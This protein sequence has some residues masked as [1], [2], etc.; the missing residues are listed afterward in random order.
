MIESEDI[1]A[2]EKVIN[3]VKEFSEK[4]LIRK[5]QINFSKLSSETASLKSQSDSKIIEKRFNR[6]LQKLR[7]IIQQDL[8]IPIYF[9][10]GAHGGVIIEDFGFCEFD[11]PEYALSTLIKRMELAIKTHIPYNLEIAACCLKWLN[12]NYPSLISRF[13]ALFNEGKFE[14]INPSYAQPYNL[15]ISAEAN[16]KQFEYGL[17]ILKELNLPCDIFYCSESSIH[18]QIPQI[19][20]GFDIKYG[21][22]RTRLLGVNP[23]SNSAVISWIGLDNTPIDALID[24]SG[25]FNGEYW[26]GTFF[27]E[28][29]NLLFQAVG[30]P[31]MDYILYSCIEDFVNELPLKE[32]VWRV[33]KYSEILGKSLLC[34]DVFQLINKDGKYKF[35]RDQFLIGDNIVLTP[36]LLLQNRNAEIS[37]ISAEF[38]HT[39]LGQFN[40]QSSDSFFEEIWEKLLLAQAHDSFAVPF[41]RTGDYSRNQLPK[42]ELEKLNLPEP[43]LSISELSIQLFLEIQTK[44]KAYI[45][46]TFKQMTK[47]SENSKEYLL[48]FNPTPYPRRDIVIIEESNQKIISEVPGFGYSRIFL[49]D[50]QNESPSFLFDVKLLNDL[51]TIQLKYKNEIFY[52]IQFKSKIPYKLKI[53]QKQSNAIEEITEIIGNMKGKKFILQITQY[54]DIDRLE[55]I[56]DSNLLSEIIIIPKIQIEDAFVNYPFGIERTKRTKIQSLDFLWLK[57]LKRGLIYIQKNSQK[58]IIDQ[59]TFQISNLIPAK[60]RYEFCISIMEN[61]SPLSHVYTYYFRLIG[62]KFDKETNLTSLNSSFLALNP[63]V[64]TVNLWTRGKETFL[65]LFNP[66]NEKL[67]F[68]LKGNLIKNQLKEINFNYKEITPLNNKFIEM[69]TWKIKTLK[70]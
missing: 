46:N 35:S 36:K 18:P 4:N 6:I 28:I 60:G 68:E 11:S 65:R 22:L 20:K 48:I 19:L 1:S 7:S 24:Q 33:S 66:S 9:L 55:F 38:M 43:S 44:C 54:N 45:K 34:S 3:L 49:N 15:I 21:S 16:I 63:P 47:N 2:L 56:L 69:D 39:I 59:D 29:P 70:L 41:I 12:Q 51:K 5:R 30:R 17:R 27:K 14:I 61:Q 10:L 23:T 50:I 62:H 26:H 52:E 67:T 53:N 32:E 64:P 25:V 13:L 58:F 8:Y 31:F 42:E 40:E 57:G 37:L